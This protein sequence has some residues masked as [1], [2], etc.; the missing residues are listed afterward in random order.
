MSRRS[1]RAPSLSAVCVN[2]VASL[3]QS[4]RRKSC[5]EFS[6]QAHLSNRVDESPKEKAPSPIGFLSYIDDDETLNKLNKPQEK[7]IQISPAEI[8]MEEYSTISL[9]F[10]NFP[11]AM[12]KT[13]IIREKGRCYFVAKDLINRGWGKEFPTLSN[14]SSEPNVHFTLD[15]FWGDMKEEYFSYLKENG[16]PGNY[17]TAFRHPKQYII[18]YIEGNGN[19]KERSIGHPQMQN[20]QIQIFKLSEPL[21]RRNIDDSQLISFL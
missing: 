6:P 4:F 2:K 3:G 21:S 20:I 8:L 17:F 5:V 16:K 1:L 13:L 10:P 11:K 14:L 9:Q 15:Y 7:L 18:C 19:P 12:L